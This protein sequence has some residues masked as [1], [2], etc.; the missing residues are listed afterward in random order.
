MPRICASNND[1]HDFCFSCYPSQ[2]D[3]DEDPQ[4]HQGEG[5]D[6]RGDCYEYDADHP[7]YDG[8]GYTCEVCGKPLTS[9]DNY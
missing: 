4:F 7:D 8:L 1:P 3:A 5:P 9:E 2:D 6:D